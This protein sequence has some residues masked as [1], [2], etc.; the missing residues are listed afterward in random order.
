[1]DFNRVVATPDIMASVGKL[2]KILGPRGLMP[3]PKVGTVTFDVGKIVKELKEGKIEFKAEKNGILQASIGKVSFGSAKLKENFI[4]LL[5]IVNRLKPASSKG[6]Y[7]KKVSL[8]STMGLGVSV[9]ILKLKN[10]LI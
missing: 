2:G 5:E 10:N 9:D 8:S 4:A 1:M 3:N 7:V 6:V